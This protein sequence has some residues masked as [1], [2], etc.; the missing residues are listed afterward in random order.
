ME[1]SLVGYVEVPH[2]MDV[3][4]YHAAGGVNQDHGTLFL[5]G[6]RIGQVGDDMAKSVVYTL[7]LPQGTH[8]IRWVLTGG[9]FQTN[10]LKFQAAK[11]GDLLS[12]YHT[13]QQRDE[14]GAA[15]AATT[16]DAQ[17]TVEGWPPVDPKA[18]IRVS[19]DRE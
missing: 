13:A 1:I 15:T 4:V 9:T 17:G 2:E 16:I 11:T 8:E 12:V 18:W 5:D 7:T 3:D 10:L 6:R 19:M 14:T